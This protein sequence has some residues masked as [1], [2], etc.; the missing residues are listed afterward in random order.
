[1][2][3]KLIA[4][5]RP[6]GWVDGSSYK[7]YSLLMEHY[8]GLITPDIKTVPK[9]DLVICHGDRWPMYK[10]PLSMGIPY[11]LV[12][13]DVYSLRTGQF[14]SDER[15]KIENA[16]AVIFTS[17]DHLEYYRSLGFKLP[18]VG[19]VPLK[20]LKKDLVFIRKPKIGGKHLVYAGGLVT[21]DRKS[22]YFG[23]RAYH[24]I[25]KAFIQAGWIVHVYVPG[26]LRRSFTDYVDI[27]C[28]VHGSLPYSTLLAEISQYTAGL[29]SYNRESVPEIAYKYTQ[30]CRPNKLW[31]YLAAG[32]P[33]IGFQGGNGMEI[34]RDKWGVVV[35][36]L[37]KE[38]LRGLD[39]NLPKITDEMRF[40][41]NMDDCMEVF[42]N[43]IDEALNSSLEIRPANKVTR[44][45][46]SNVKKN[47][48]AVNKT[49]R[50]VER[51]NLVFKPLESK[52]LINI[53]RSLYM[54]IKSCSDL[55]VHYIKGGK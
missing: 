28:I 32:I 24:G 7:Y 1:M 55:E 41:E 51:G 22:S 44:I 36:N 47:I 12:E 45:S 37:N 20:P 54:Q 40:K 38:T 21:H 15:E 9:P 39:K 17:E 2:M 13:H 50:M 23:Y 49:G 4:Y 26:S 43:F 42:K 18:P 8:G 19:I 52:E 5:M 3:S 34:Y 33:T 31:D 16:F 25:F 6:P 10:Q 35:D 11:I 30:L 14:Y 29:Q 48:I 46:V 53:D 27:G